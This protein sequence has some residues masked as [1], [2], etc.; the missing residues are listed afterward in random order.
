MSKFIENMV[1]QMKR[2]LHL[3]TSLT[4]SKDLMYHNYIER[5]I[6]MEG[7]LSKKKLKVLLLKSSY[8]PNEKHSQLYQVISH[9]IPSNKSYTTGG[10][11]V[12]GEKFTISNPKW[13]IIDGNPI[14]PTRY[15]I[16]YSTEESEL[17]Y[18]FD[19]EEEY[20]AIDHFFMINIDSHGLFNITD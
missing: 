6:W 10:T 4:E 18:C 14:G 7:N 15:G 5:I 11:E 1:D 8:K 16:L 3:K 13:E 19:F 12:I 20:T 9:E 2:F 17:I